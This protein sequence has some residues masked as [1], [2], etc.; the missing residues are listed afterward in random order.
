[1]DAERTDSPAKGQILQQ[2]GLV[3]EV[4]VG[5]LQEWTP[6]AMQLLQHKRRMACKQPI[7]CLH[8]PMEKVTHSSI[9]GTGMN[10]SR[11]RRFCSKSQI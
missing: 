8:F 2:K 11:A 10:E 4:N 6:N 1:M 9:W 3:K 5:Y 7:E